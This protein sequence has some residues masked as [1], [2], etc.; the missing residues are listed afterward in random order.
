MALQELQLL[1]H[2]LPRNVN[3]VRLLAVDTATGSVQY[4][5]APG[6]SLCDA[7]FCFKGDYA[8]RLMYARPVAV[9]VAAGLLHLHNSGVVHRN[10]VPESITLC[11]GS[12]P[13]IGGFDCCTVDAG[14]RVHTLIGTPEYMAPEMLAGQQSST[15]V[16]WW[17]FGCLLHEMILG[18]SPFG[19][20]TEVA[21][22]VEHILQSNLQLDSRLGAAEQ[23]LLNCFLVR[24][25]VHRLSGLH[26]LSNPW[27]SST[28][29]P[30]STLTSL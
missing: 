30:V 9:G 4:D 16:D 3:V 13:M 27:F 7:I 18:E 19:R 11:A 24:D 6:M 22:L 12:V 29:S 1:H 17:A 2:D 26:A 5:E 14:P 25:P 28:A 10:L 23:H 8:S 15:K 21:D 20:Y